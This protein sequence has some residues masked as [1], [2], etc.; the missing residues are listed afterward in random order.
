MKK[1]IKITL[2]VAVIALSSAN[3]AER[4]P[5]LP[6]TWSGPAGKDAANSDTSKDVNPLVRKSLSSYKVIG[7]V[8]SPNDAL[9]VL[10]TRDR[11]EYFVYVGDPI[12]SEGGII[13]TINSEG[14]TVDIGGK[15][16]SLKVSNRF[17][18][19]DD[20]QKDK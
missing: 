17:E 4:D 14:I 8:V 6:Y 11:G 3:A 5:F 15:I 1:L 20:T 7:V 10:K 12:G 19:Q 9:A 13:E 18:S 2:F 16:V